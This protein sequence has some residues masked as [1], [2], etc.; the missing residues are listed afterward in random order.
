VPNYVSQKDS[1]I[2]GHTHDCD[3]ERETTLRT[4][5]SRGALRGGRGSVR[6]R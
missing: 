4:F 6:M 5:A 1:H 3:S 2:W